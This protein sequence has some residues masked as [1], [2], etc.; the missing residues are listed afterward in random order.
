MAAEGEAAGTPGLR[1]L[2]DS[3]TAFFAAGVCL[4]AAYF[5][6][7]FVLTPSEPY[8]RP[9]WKPLGTAMAGLLGLLCFEEH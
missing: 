9:R 2:A 1:R 6:L 4:A 5:S 7:Q 8:L 3:L